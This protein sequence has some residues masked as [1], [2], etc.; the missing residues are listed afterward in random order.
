[1]KK[2]QTILIMAILLFVLLLAGFVYWDQTR[3]YKIQRRCTMYD[4]S[5]IE[6]VEDIDLY[7]SLNE[8]CA[9]KC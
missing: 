2:K 4:L 8:K 6:N 9:G 5:E 1:M 7:R 3:C